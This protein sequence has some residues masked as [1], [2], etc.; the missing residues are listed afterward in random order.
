MLNAVQILD[1]ILDFFKNL[2]EF[3]IDS[4]PDGTQPSDLMFAFAIGGFLI[5]L[6]ASWIKS[7]KS[8]EIKLMK[9]IDGMNNYFYNN[10]TVNSD[11]L[12]EFNNRMKNVPKPVR[13]QWQNYMLKRD[14]EP[15]EYLSI[16]NC[17]ERPLR[18][19]SYQ[20][21]VR[22]SSIGFNVYMIII[23][24]IIC[25]GIL[26]SPATS[27]DFAPALFNCL[28][29]PAIVYV[30]KFLYKMILNVRY[31][32]I[33]NDIYTGFNI[34][35]RAID[36]ASATLPEYIEY[37]MLFTKKEIKDRIPILQ[38]YI[39]RRERKEREELEKAKNSEVEHENF[40]FKAVGVNAS[41]LLERA[42]RESETYTNNKKRL[43][44]KIAQKNQELQ[45]YKTNYENLNKEQLR[46]QQV[47]KENL[48]RLRHSA[49]TS[50]NRVEASRIAKQQEEELKR[51]EQLEKDAQTAY[52]KYIKEKDVIDEQ[53]KALEA[54]LAEK[55]KY[56]EDIMM[57]EFKTYTSRLYDNLAAETE[58]KYSGI[59]SEMKEDNEILSDEIKDKILLLEQHGIE[60]SPTLRYVVK[61][62]KDKIKE[63][64][65]QKEIDKQNEARLQEA[66]IVKKQSD[67]EENGNDV[68]SETSA[69]TTSAETAVNNEAQAEVK[70]IDE[71]KL[72]DDLKAEIAGGQDK[73]K[74]EL[75]K[76]L[77]DELRAE[78]K[79]EFDKQKEDDKKYDAFG[80]YYDDF[81]NYIYR[82]GSYY[83]PD[84]N[85]FDA[86]G[87][88]LVPASETN[89]EGMVDEYGGHY[90]SNGNYIYED[91]S[92]YDPQGNFY[93]E[94][95]NLVPLDNIE[96]NN[97][98]NYD[99]AFGQ[100][101]VAE[102]MY[103]DETERL[104]ANKDETNESDNE[105]SKSKN[106]ESSNGEE[107]K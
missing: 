26:F 103:K 74:D 95:G 32:S 7:N 90:D 45:D 4:A 6:I 25:G 24:A 43:L 37:E 48:E 52:D 55:K 75:R 106:D 23:T 68:P 67:M 42:M 46:Q 18:Y 11:N 29:I 10:P 93:D 36:K 77:K 47:S 104:N 28:M 35:Q 78:I 41:L 19:T 82:D 63:A 30:L 3:V 20:N 27:T 39:E 51:Q 91:G 84:G 17:I 64:E 56:V 96:N 34:F 92:Y 31:S 70:Q 100:Q 61:Q 38:D 72:K 60:S 85:Y 58:E 101:D 88:L 98:Q 80:G 5:Y 15:S 9:S 73:I 33:V 105:E 12:K 40:D 2:G 53:V 87:H 69:E 22:N 86:N 1:K 102:E 13:D 57:A 99:D 107:N 76:Q 49:E 16:E 83:D 59:I 50:T 65:R 79:D 89:M 62:Q 94:N 21:S 54:E 71:Q 97:M 81:G 44:Y 66:M 14:K 8:Y